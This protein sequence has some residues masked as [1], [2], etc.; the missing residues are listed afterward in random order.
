MRIPPALKHR[1]FLMYWIGFMISAIGSQ[2]QLWAIY[3][4]LRTLS[5]QPLVISGIGFAR[6]LPVILLSLFAGVVAD[7]FNRRK[8]AI[9]TQTML[10]L[11]ALVLGVLTFLNKTQLWTIYV[12]VI[13]QSIAVSFD[14]PARQSLI[15]SLVPREDLPSAY[16]M[17]SISSNVGSILGPAIC[18]LVIAYLGL[19]WAYWINAISYIAVIMALFAMGPVQSQIKR[20]RLQFNRTILDIKEGIQFIRNSPIILSSMIVDFVA[21][22][23]SSANTLLPFVARDIL[24]VGAIQY[25]WLSAA[26]SVGTVSVALVVSQRRH[27]HRQGILLTGA[28]II[29]GLA[30]VVF[31]LSTSF[32]IT[33]AAL[34]L[35]GAADGLNTIIR[36][37]LRQL[38]TP[39]SMRGRMLS[40]N[41]IFFKGGPQ[42]GEVESGLVAQA[43]GVPFAI[44]SGGIGCVIAVAFV[45]SRFPQLF[46]YNGDEPMVL[47]QAVEQNGTVA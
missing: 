5:D 31:G 9:V 43:F 33:M 14:L 22:F 30:T 11:V 40:I 38:Q 47:E 2:M 15:P 45:I 37:T 46:R 39:D 28:V 34:I 36:N 6:F 44:V 35:I 12:M 7:H 41:M 42:L 13:I 32:W 8:V 20:T 21:S 19:Q 27:I 4:H 25:G 17:N 23:F 24:H 18:G 10:I 29:F 3:W 1:S 16:S 26:Q